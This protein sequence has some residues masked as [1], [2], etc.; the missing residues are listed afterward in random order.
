MDFYLALGNAGIKLDVAFVDGNHDFEFAY[1]DIVMA[2]RL[3]CPGGVIVIDNAEQSGPFYAAAQFVRENPDWIEL[4]DAIASF[5]LSTPFATERAT[6]PHG[7]FLAI[8]SPDGYAVGRVPRTTGQVQAPPSI[9]GFSCNIASEGYRGTLHYQLIL[10]AFRDENREI[11]EYRRVGQMALDSAMTPREIRH[12]L[13][14]PLVSP[15]H[16]RHGDCTHTLE[17]ELAWEAEEG[18]TI[19]LAS[20]PVAL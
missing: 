19:L 16:Q 8:R 9:E 2:A 4:G 7:G 14:Q 5:K 10:R 3:L 20:P 17:A 12:R 18:S 6:I 11:E 1:F 13:D 15:L